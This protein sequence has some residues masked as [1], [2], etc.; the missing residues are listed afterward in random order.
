ME[1]RGRG[2]VVARSLCVVAHGHGVVA[3]CRG[4]GVV[5]H[6]RGGGVV[7]R[8]HGVRAQ[9]NLPSALTEVY[10]QASLGPLIPGAM[11]QI[12]R[13]LQHPPRGRRP[14]LFLAGILATHPAAESGRDI[15]TEQTGYRLRRCGLRPPQQ[16]AGTSLGMPPFPGRGTDRS[17]ALQLRGSHEDSPGFVGVDGAT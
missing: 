16:T 3:H 14:R 15:M 6:C 12:S 17:A 7:A 1:S 10:R 13:Q 4:G 2:G 8:G 5:A 11:T 9:T